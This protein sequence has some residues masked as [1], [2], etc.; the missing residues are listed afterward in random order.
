MKKPSLDHT[1]SATGALLVIL[2]VFHVSETLGIT[3]DELAMVI[4]A[5]ATLAGI[6]RHKWERKRTP[7]A[8]TQGGEW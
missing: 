3:G 5:V 7:P 4:G 2:G 8:E 1:A 6:L